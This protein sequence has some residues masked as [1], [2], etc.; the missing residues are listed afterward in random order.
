MFQ[1][2]SIFNQARRPAIILA[3]PPK[4]TAV[5]DQYENLMHDQFFFVHLMKT[6]GT[7]LAMSLQ[8]QF[9]PKEI[10]PSQ[11]IDARDSAD[12]AA[13]GSLKR[14][15]ALSPERRAEIRVFTGHFPYVAS[16]LLNLDLVRLTILRE[17]IERT[18][19][20][21]KQFKRRTKR[22]EELS[23]DEIYEDQHVFSHYIENHQAM[24]F[25]VT[26]DD[27]PEAL[28]SPMTYWATA[29]LNRLHAAEQNEETLAEIERVREIS[30]AHAPK[31]DAARLAR[32]KENLERVDVVGL[33]GDYGEFIDELRRR[34]G[35]WPD[36]LDADVRAN[37]SPESWDV[38]GA[39]RKRIEAD[40][41][42]D[43]EFYE[44][45]RELIARRRRPQPTRGGQAAPVTISKKDRRDATDG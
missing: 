31:V 34:F 27:R 38:S 21:L 5:P 28:G 13:Y 22:V 11:G 3:A 16:E 17:P 39:L 2:T 10:Y 1:T 32:A 6:A 4:R 15:L 8:R 19:S 41:R 33:S 37:R 23:L 42:G 18:V 24:M 12:I 7:S 40:N 43:M 9:A 14:L 45:A 26:A 35:W 20:V 36:G 44:Y 29:T 25:S 30:A